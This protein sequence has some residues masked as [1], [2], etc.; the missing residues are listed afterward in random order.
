MYGAILKYE[1]ILSARSSNESQLYSA[2]VGYDN[3]PG[4]DPSRLRYTRFCSVCPLSKVW[5]LC[6]QK[7]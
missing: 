1:T 7:K 4:N 6:F 3:R 2:A 5:I